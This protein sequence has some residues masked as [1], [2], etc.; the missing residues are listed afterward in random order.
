MGKNWYLVAAGLALGVAPAVASSLFTIT[1]TFNSSITSDPNAAAIESTINNVIDI[2]EAT[3]SNPITVDITFGEMSSGLGESEWNYFVGVPYSVYC[4]DLVATSTIAA[5]TLSPCGTDNPVTGSS[6]INVKTVDAN[7]VGLTG[8]SGSGTILL[9]TSL[10][11]PGSPGSS[12]QYALAAVTEHE[13]DEVLGLGSGLAN[14]TSGTV[15]TIDANG[16]PFPEDLYRFSAPGVRNFNTGT[17]CGSLGG[18][19]FSINDGTTNLDGFNNA[20]NGGDFGDWVINSPGQVQ[21][22]AATGGNPSLGVEITAL[23][24]IGYNLAAPEPST[25]V[26]VG[27]VLLGAGLLRRRSAVRR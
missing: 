19:Y 26:L 17:P 22:W 11:N 24:A 8:T 20:C 15:T 5:G 21:D 6:G 18:A 4:A 2:Y 25:F 13:I 23:E 1:P 14:T 12:N 9:N 16:D 27:S 10:T 3:F 7:A